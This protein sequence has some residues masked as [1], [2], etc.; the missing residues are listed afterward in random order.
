[1]SKPNRRGFLIKGS[2]RRRS[3]PGRR[4]ACP[5][6]SATGSASAPPVRP[7]NA[8]ERAVETGANLNP[9]DIQIIDRPGSDYMVDV[10]KSLGF[11]YI[12]ANPGSSFRG[13]ARI[14]HQLRRQQEPEFIT[15]CHEESSRRHGATATPRS[16]ASR[17]R[18][19]ARHR[20][21]A[22]RRHGRSTTPTATARPYS[23]CSATPRRGRRAGAASNGL[24]SVQDAAAMVRDFTKWDDIPPRSSTSRESAVRAY[25]FAMTPPLMPV[26]LVADG[27]LQE[28]PMRS[29]ER[30]S[31]SEV[32]WS[33]SP[34]AGRSGSRDETRAHACGRRKPGHRCR[35]RSARTPAGWKL[36]VELAEASA[37]AR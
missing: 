8:A 6:G 37:S 28:N 18:H 13:A 27:E 29:G 16:K 7:P 36:L 23:W 25:Q 12:F 9:V 17:C 5:R 20:R 1:M 14:A 30:S 32:S 4:R 34:P 3:H 26:L 11:E 35:S 22:A 31:R 21:A 2:D 10:L 24:H 15:C 19:G 33:P